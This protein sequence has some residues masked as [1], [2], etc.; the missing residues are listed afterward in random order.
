MSKVYIAGKI[1][2]EPNFKENFKRVMDH[3]EAEGHAVMNPATL[4]GGF[5]YEEYMAVCFKMIDQC[6]TVLLLNNWQE[7]PGAKREHRY[8]TDK[9][10]SIWTQPRQATPSSEQLEALRRAPIIVMH[11]Q[12][13]DAI[14]AA[15]YAV[16]AKQAYD[17]AAPYVPN[18]EW[19]HNKHIYRAKIYQG[20]LAY[21]LHSNPD[22]CGWYMKLR[23]R[24][25]SKV[26]YMQITNVKPGEI[27]AF[28]V[29]KLI[30]SP[31]YSHPCASR[32]LLTVT[33]EDVPTFIASGFSDKSLIADLRN[34]DIKKAI[35]VKEKE[36]EDLK[37][38]LVNEL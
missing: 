33:G 27:P 17:A 9:G 30:D 7:S 14:T 8:A 35:S 5:D 25:N 32:I 23:K 21:L 6:D 38:Q 26:G 16:H 11:K 28:V 37:A 31:D 34:N 10:K 18:T 36:L 4:R 12:A 13:D 2:D 3:L 22:R 1:T 15:L 24:T 29:S 20:D 19:E